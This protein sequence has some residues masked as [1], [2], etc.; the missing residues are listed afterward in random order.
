MGYKTKLAILVGLILLGA[1]STSNFLYFYATFIP[2]HFDQADTLLQFYDA[3]YFW[4]DGTSPVYDFFAALLKLQ[5]MKGGLTQDIGFLLSILLGP[6]RLSLWLANFGALVLF[7]VVVYNYVSRAMSK[8]VALIIATL[9]LL[10]PSIY[11]PAGGLYDLRWDFVGIMM[12][13]CFLFSFWKLINQNTRTNM[14]IAVAFSLIAID[15]R[16]TNMVYVGLTISG[17]ALVFLLLLTSKSLRSYALAQ[18]KTM[19]ILGTIVLMFYAVFGIIH[20]AEINSYYLDRTLPGRPL[21]GEQLV[22]I[23]ESGAE[24]GILMYYIQSTFRMYKPYIVYPLLALAALWAY[25]WISCRRSLHPASP[26]VTTGFVVGEFRW[27]IEGAVIAI[28]ATVSVL[29]PASLYAPGPIPPSY[30]LGAYLFLIVCSVPPVKQKEGRVFLWV[31]LI[32]LFSFAVIRV[33]SLQSWSKSELKSQNNALQLYQSVLSNNPEGGRIFFSVVDESM[34]LEAFRIWLYEN[35]NRRVKEKFTGTW[36][37][38][39]PLSS[40]EYDSQ[41]S[42][43]DIIFRWMQ[44]PSK[45]L[46]PSEEQLKG[47]FGKTSWARVSS[48]FVLLKEVPYKD[49]VMGVYARR[50]RA[51]D[52]FAPF[53]IEGGKWFWLG[54]GHDARIS[55]V[56]SAATVLPVRISATLGLGPSVPTGSQVK[57]CVTSGNLVLNCYPVSSNNDDF[58]VVVPA[59]PGASEIELSVVHDDD[60]IFL[61]VPN[62]SR[63]LLL[64]V[65]NLRISEVGQ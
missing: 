62:D 37:E 54:D 11:M 2:R 3:H 53:G 36:L 34:L 38:I 48:Q 56:N 32:A 1:V 49:G 29:V 23:K 57:L 52:I 41:L 42:E 8:E 24:G 20:W 25:W 21:A 19:L 26:S 16:S 35:G 55:I 18:I 60:M 28:V 51:T 12:F 5:T 61:P 30:L 63:H 46:Y 17:V 43:S 6:N 44:A 27:R 58:E 4:K 47:E 45:S 22:R 39:L 31:I 7:L 64:N 10:G 40:I 65:S 59:D 15:G 33:G 50:V 9:A 13:G 14:A